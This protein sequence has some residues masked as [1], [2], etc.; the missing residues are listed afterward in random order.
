MAFFGDFQRFV[1]G[2][3]VIAGMTAIG[4]IY[5]SEGFAVAADGRK[6]RRA[7]NS[8]LIDTAQKIFALNDSH[9]PIAY[10]FAGTVGLAPDDKPD[11]ATVDFI[12]ETQKALAIMDTDTPHSLKEFV[13]KL[14]SEIES[15]LRGAKSANAFQSYPEGPPGSEVPGS[16]IIAHIL[17]DGYYR[18]FPGRVNATF[19]HKDQELIATEVNQVNLDFGMTGY[20]PGRVSVNKPIVRLPFT[21]GREHPRD[22]TAFGLDLDYAWDDLAEVLDNCWAVGPCPR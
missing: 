18:G 1:G 4:R 13:A 5:T 20:G 2:S 19:V 8:A 6:S 12:I 17:F 9:R 22:L 14:C 3:G 21:A 7:D 10:R 11:E 15:A 16:H